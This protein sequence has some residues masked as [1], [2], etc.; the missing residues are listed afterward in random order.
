MNNFR[1]GHAE[2]SPTGM[3]QH[4]LLGKELRRR[5]VDKEGLLS[6]SYVPTEL[7]VRSSDYNRTIQ[8]AQSQLMGLYPPGSGPELESS[9][10]MDHAVPP[11][12]VEGA[13]DMK[14]DLGYKA[15]PFYFQSIPIH[16]KERVAESA[17]VPQYGCPKMKTN[18]KQAMKNSEYI[19]FVQDEIEPLKP[20]LEEMTGLSGDEITADRTIDIIDQF[21]VANFDGKRVPEG[22]DQATLSKFKEVFSWWFFRY[23]SALGEN[24]RM[25]TSVFF[26]E[27]NEWFNK[28]IAQE[29]G[30]KFALYSAHDSTLSNLLNALNGQVRYITYAS[31][32]MFE[33]HSGDRGYYVK[34]LFNDEELH[35]P[36]CQDPECTLDEFVI[37]ASKIIL[38]DWEKACEI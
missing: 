26:K 12:H 13:E 29:T 6:A 4:Y 2:L 34:V 22:L 35:I 20:L 15:L 33:L 32:I 18:V 5:Y 8:S 14:Q 30:V 19:N 10:A 25:M 27:L 24:L 28:V 7:Y 37:F 31:T 3:R 17:L 9:Y 21:L 16:V 38:P 23:K 11:I 36:G 1:Y